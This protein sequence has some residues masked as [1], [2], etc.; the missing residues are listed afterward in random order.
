VRVLA[1]ELM[2]I[3]VAQHVDAEQY[4][5]GL[6]RPGERNGYRDRT[7]DTRVGSIDLR[8]PRVRDGGY[9]PA[10]LEPRRR[11]ERALVA[12]VQEAYVQGVSTRRV[13]ELVKALGLSGISPINEPASAVETGGG[14]GL[15]RA[16]VRMFESSAARLGTGEVATAGVAGRYELVGPLGAGAMGRVYRARDTVLDRLVALKLIDDQPDAARDAIR[17]ARA[18]ARVAHPSLARVFD[19]GVADDRG[20][21]VMELIEGQSLAT[22]LRQRGALPS[23]E[24]VGL[25]SRL[26]DGLHAAH[27]RG[28]IHCD[29]KP[30]NILVTPAGLPKLVDFGIARIVGGTRTSRPG[31][32]VGSAHYV[33][34][35]QIHGERATAAVDVYALGVVLYEALTGAPPFTGDSAA[36][37]LAQKTLRPP[38]SPRPRNGT[39]SPDLQHVVLTALA[40]DP[41]HRFGSAAA[42]RDALECVASGRPNTALAATAP[43]PATHTSRTRRGRLARTALVIATVLGG[44]VLLAVGAVAERPS[45]SPSPAAEVAN[46]SAPTANTPAGPSPRPL[47]TE[48]PAEG[49]PDRGPLTVAGSDRSK[50]SKPADAKSNGRAEPP[51]KAR[52]HQN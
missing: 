38:P 20:Y 46:N 37:I 5:R 17:E 32:I 24:A 16:H 21:V 4:E 45:V 3:E 43:L 19:W 11:G 28:V 6:A 25:I 40:M 36:Q 50:P 8:V 12:V 48:V 51:G 14:T 31:E 18:A 39:L 9:Y 49:A 41:S 26:A 22:L 7:W 2:Q 33:A 42:L 44:V 1:Q 15:A 27:Q 30:Q 47:P 52:G 10:L 29:V 35:E 34:P 23:E 13:D